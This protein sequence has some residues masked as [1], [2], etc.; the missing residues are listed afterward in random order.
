MLAPR[1][2]ARAF[3]DLRPMTILSSRLNPRA[4]DFRAAAENMRAL[5]AD[6]KAQVAK[7]GDGGG[8]AAR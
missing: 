3:T 8:A 1:H 2:A 5:V 6:L 7:V 4:E